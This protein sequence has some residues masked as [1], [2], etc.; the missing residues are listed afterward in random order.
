MRSSERGSCY[1]HCAINKSHYLFLTLLEPKIIL[2]SKL[3]YHDYGIL[4]PKFLG[5]PELYSLPITFFWGAILE[6]YKLAN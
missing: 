6:I 3:H 2:S 4:K 1:H 5:L